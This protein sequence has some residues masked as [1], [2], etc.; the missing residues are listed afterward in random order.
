V[1]SSLSVLA[2]E[3]CAVGQFPAGKLL[4]P[5]TNELP[6]VVEADACRMG[7]NQSG[8]ALQAAAMPPGAILQSSDG[9][10]IKITYQYLSHDSFSIQTLS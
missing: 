1:A 5:P 6:C 8:L 7:E 3:L 9:L 2:D 4:V 10:V